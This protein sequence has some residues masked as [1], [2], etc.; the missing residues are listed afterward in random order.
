M[1]FCT[2]KE[3][4]QRVQLLALIGP[5]KNAFLLIYMGVVGYNEHLGAKGNF[6]N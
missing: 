2:L 6:F 1:F 5:K 3:V 4:Q